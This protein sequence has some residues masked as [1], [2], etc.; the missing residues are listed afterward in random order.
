MHQSGSGRSFCCDGHADALRAIVKRFRLKM[1]FPV[2][3]NTENFYGN[4]T[5]NL[6]RDGTKG[7]ILTITERDVPFAC[8]PVAACVGVTFQAYKRE[9]AK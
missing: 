5:E 8:C 3:K 9:T 1:L 6:L 2:G 7:D 4:D